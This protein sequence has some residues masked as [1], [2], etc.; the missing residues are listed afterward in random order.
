MLDRRELGVPTNTAAQP[1]QSLSPTVAT[2]LFPGA[3]P[4][5]LRLAA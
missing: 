4:T 5:A 2:Y 3:K 1:I